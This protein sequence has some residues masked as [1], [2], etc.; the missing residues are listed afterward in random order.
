MKG[1]VESPGSRIAEFVSISPVA[2][3]WHTFMLSTL[4]NITALQCR[5]LGGFA[6]PSRHEDI[7]E[8][9]G[10]GQDDVSED[11]H[12]GVLDDETLA[13]QISRLGLNY[14]A[15][16]N[17]NDFDEYDA[18]VPE[19]TDSFSTT[20]SAN[21]L[22]Y[23]T[24]VGA[25]QSGRATDTSSRGTDSERDDEG[26]WNV[27]VSNGGN[28]VD[29]N[30]KKTDRG[31]TGGACNNAG[32]ARF[33][34][35]Y[36]NDVGNDVPSTSPLADFDAF[37]A[38]PSMEDTSAVNGAAFI[39]TGDA[40]SS[41]PEADDFANWGD[42]D[43]SCANGRTQSAPHGKARLPFYVC[44][45]FHQFISLPRLGCVQAS[46]LPIFR[47]FRHLPPWCRCPHPLQAAMQ[48]YTVEFWT[49]FWIDPIT[50]KLSFSSETK[51]SHS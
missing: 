2:D 9:Y 6:Y 7:M 38:S 15:D 13:E 26:G 17:E 8:Y 45:Y 24:A 51:S 16:N 42:G 22:G 29:G 27:A 48:V 30:G 34:D 39:V 32:I 36:I 47:T 31:E 40:G 46:H 18:D 44:L 12:G 49:W 19:D 5:P 37:P 41:E 4:S 20:V 25:S 33:N 50:E 43:M 21:M 10:A 35:S 1:I 23:G 28:E 14:G 11:D 3:E